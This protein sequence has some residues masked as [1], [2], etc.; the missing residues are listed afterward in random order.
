M[1]ARKFVKIM[2]LVQL[3]LDNR[4]FSYPEK[5]ED[6]EYLFKY[7]G[8]KPTKAQ[9]IQLMKRNKSYEKEG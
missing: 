7:N 5:E 9:M 1:D 2:N 6:I 8:I 4:T 3:I